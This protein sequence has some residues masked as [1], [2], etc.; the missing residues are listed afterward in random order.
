MIGQF[1]GCLRIK[2]ER[3]PSHLHPFDDGRKD[4]FLQLFLVPDKIVVN[5]ENLAP[6]PCRV[7]TLELPDDLVFVLGARC[8]SAEQGNVAKLAVEGA[9]AGILDID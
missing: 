9:A 8:T 5:K 7:Y 6:E 1:Y 4:L 3:M 2:G